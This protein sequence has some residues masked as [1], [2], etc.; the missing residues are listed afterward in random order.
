MPIGTWVSYKCINDV[1]K[2]ENRA[3]KKTAYAIEEI[4]PKRLSLKF[5]NTVKVKFLI[6]LFNLFKI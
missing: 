4:K 5:Q 6:K 2:V 3:I 1:I